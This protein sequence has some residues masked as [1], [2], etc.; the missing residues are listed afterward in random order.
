MHMKTVAVMLLLLTCVSTGFAAD[1]LRQAQNDD[2]REAVFR[3]QIDNARPSQKE[4]AEVYFLA[5]AGTE[6]DDPPTFLPLPLGDE[7]HDPSDE[8]MHRLNPNKPPLLRNS[9]LRTRDNNPKRG[10]RF[11]VTTIKWISAEEVEVK[12]G[13]DDYW[14]TEWKTFT[15]RKENGKWKVTKAEL[16]RAVVA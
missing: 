12:G 16:K 14:S 4:K 10:L 1:S 7:R 13:H 11:R 6:N 2:I 8:L 5:V 15:V 9:A 3:Y